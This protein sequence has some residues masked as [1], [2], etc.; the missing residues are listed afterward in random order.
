MFGGKMS[1]KAKRKVRTTP[2]APRR[3]RFPVG[4]HI[5]YEHHK[6]YPFPSKRECHRKPFLDSHY[7]VVGMRNHSVPPHFTPSL[8]GQD[9]CKDQGS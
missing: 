8:T 6:Q 7:F 4:S 1:R 5:V 2:C 9:P 3:K